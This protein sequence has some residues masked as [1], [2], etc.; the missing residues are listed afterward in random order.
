MTIPI[1]E[2]SG[3]YI[4]SGMTIR[5]CRPYVSW[6]GHRSFAAA[7]DDNG[8]IRW[9]PPANGSTGPGSTTCGDDEMGVES[10]PPADLG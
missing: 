1:E 7:Q 9:I 8:G 3:S 2:G 6:A 5:F 10:G 4:C